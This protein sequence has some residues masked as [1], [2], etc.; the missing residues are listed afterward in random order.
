MKRP[1]LVKVVWMMSL[2]AVACGAVF[3]RAAEDLIVQAYR[4]GLRDVDQ[5]G[6]WAVM[7]RFSSPV[8]PSNVAQNTTV[9]MRGVGKPFQ[10]LE[11][12]SRQK[13]TKATT[14]LILVPKESSDKP[15]SV[16]VFI[17]KGL[18]DATGRRLLAKD[19]AYTFLAY[20]QISVTHISSFY[21]SKKERGVRLTLSSQVS[22]QDLSPA[23]E[24]H[25]KVDKLSIARD[26]G[27]NYTITGEFE[28]NEDYVLKISPEKVANGTAVL[29]FKEFRFKGPGV[30]PEIAVNSDGSVVELKSRQ[31]LPLRLTNVTKV[32]CE[33]VKVPALLAAEVSDALDTPRRRKEADREKTMAGSP[34]R[35]PKAH[36]PRRREASRYRADGRRIQTGCSLQQRES[37]LRRSGQRRRGSLFRQRRQGRCLGVFAAALLS[38]ESRSRGL[39]ARDPERPGHP[40]R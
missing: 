33:M 14:S 26:Q 30:K 10:L 19:F 11:H 9:T 1:S 23:I 37:A 2:V 36:S 5:P 18:S 25:P 6:L 40:E 35:V 16:T 28:F 13:A 17:S 15:S 3:A 22:E 4:Y 21:T 12:D 34:C 38:Q 20:E 7:L 27:R 29:E 39:L 8:F 31:L 32:R 24:V